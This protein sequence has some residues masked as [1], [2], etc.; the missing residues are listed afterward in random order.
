MKAKEYYEKYKDMLESNDLEL[1]K[2]A[3]K[4]LVSE[5]HEETFNKLDKTR[6]TFEVLDTLIKQNNQKFNAVI[7][8][9]DNDYIDKDKAR[10]MFKRFEDDMIK[11]TDKIIKEE[12]RNAEHKSFVQSLVFDMN[13]GE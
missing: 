3:F 11:E 1:V 13:K 6:R 7:T 8:S 5:L 10:G 4:L 12:K 9:I 2:E